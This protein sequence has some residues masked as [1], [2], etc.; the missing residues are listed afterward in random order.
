MAKRQTID[1]WER[2]WQKHWANAGMT[3]ELP[4]KHAHERDFLMQ[5]RTPQAEK[6]RLK[7]IHDE[8]M[9]GFRRLYKLGPAVTVFGS[10]RFNEGHRYYKPGF[11]R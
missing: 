10:A 6:A 9:R 1:Q 8:F 11:P 2:G 5:T 7:R 4:A 3:Y